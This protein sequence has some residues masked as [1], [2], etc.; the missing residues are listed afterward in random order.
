VHGGAN[1]AANARMSVG[2]YAHVS[3]LG[4]GL[5]AHGADLLDGGVLYVGRKTGGGLVRAF[6]GEHWSLPSL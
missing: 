5:V 4:K 3:I 6:N 2:H 1:G